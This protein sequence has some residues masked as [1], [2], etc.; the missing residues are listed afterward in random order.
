VTD[1]TR[2]LVLSKVSVLTGEAHDALWSYVGH[3][4]QEGEEGEKSPSR[5]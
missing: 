4:E 2:T 5:R 1:N 3:K